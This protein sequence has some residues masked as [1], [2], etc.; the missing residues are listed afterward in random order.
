M[1]RTWKGEY[2]IKRSTIG[3][4][5]VVAVGLLL[6]A[7]PVSARGIIEGPVVYVESQDLF[8]DSIV[9]AME[10]PPDGTFHQQV[11]DVT[12]SKDNGAS[13]D[14]RTCE[15]SGPGES[16]LCAMWTDPDFDPSRRAVCYARVLENPSCRFSTRICNAAPEG[17][18][19]AGCSDPKLPATI[20]ERAWTSPV[21]YTP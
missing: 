1:P 13:V 2:V 11:V 8:Y 10:L 17:S 3:I 6:D 14:T 4:V 16:Q 20:Q 12:G 5:A 15:V 9:A 21:W 19:P 7:G 18:K